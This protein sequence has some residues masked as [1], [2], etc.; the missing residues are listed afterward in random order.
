MTRHSELSAGKI[1]KFHG[2]LVPDKI[3]A[4]RN[5]FTFLRFY[6]FTDV[7][8]HLIGAREICETACAA[9]IPAHSSRR[10]NIGNRSGSQR[11]TRKDFP[12]GTDSGR[13]LLPPF[14]PRQSPW[15]HFLAPVSIAP[16]GHVSRRVCW[17]RGHP[18]SCVP[19]TVARGTRAAATFSPAAGSTAPARRQRLTLLKGL[20]PE[21]VGPH[22][23]P[24]ASES[25]TD[26]SY[27]P[28]VAPTRISLAIRTTM[29]SVS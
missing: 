26:A 4:E 12:A 29:R 7:T 3:P 22:Y 9:S 5:V 17:R 25:S 28:I 18:A 19:P 11:R 24:G 2:A 8:C 13:S 21:C 23:N 20:F 15:H 14:L 16:P 27:D 6:V 1:R 10:M